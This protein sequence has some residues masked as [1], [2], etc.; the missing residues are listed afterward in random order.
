MILKDYKKAQK[1]RK[2]DKKFKKREDERR[3]QE[4]ALKILKENDE[5][6]LKLRSRLKTKEELKKLLINKNNLRPDEIRKIVKEHRNE[7]T[8]RKRPLKI[9][10]KKG[11]RILKKIQSKLEKEKLIKKVS[12]IYSQRKDEIFHG[13]LLL[14]SV[15]AKNNENIT[16]TEFLEQVQP[17]TLRTLRE[18]NNSRKDFDPKILKN[19]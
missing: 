19:S 8:R 14:Y 11:S 13:K 5:K 10:R 3:K 12:N 1:R 16:L 17:K 15:Y 18:N 2:K 7:V 4:E 9:G 6:E